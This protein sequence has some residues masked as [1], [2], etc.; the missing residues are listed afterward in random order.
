MNNAINSTH[1]R[2]CATDAFPEQIIQ[3]S[4]PGS[5]ASP[6]PAC[7]TAA[8]RE[9][10]QRN[11]TGGRGDYLQIDDSRLWHANIHSMQFKLGR[12]LTRTWLARRLHVAAR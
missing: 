6:I 7:E 5:L 12:G 11:K 3:A 2:N 9:A 10:K 8:S 1:G 4:N